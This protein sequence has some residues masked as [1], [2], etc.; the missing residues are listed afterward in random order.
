MFVLERATKK[1]HGDLKLWWF[2]LDIAKKQKAFSRVTE[3]LTKL[4]RLH[5]TKAEVW[6][7]A[8]RYAIDEHGDM[9]EAR[10][11]FQRGLRFCTNSKELWLSYARAELNYM[12][13]IITRQQILGLID[14]KTEQKNGGDLDDPNADIV[15]LPAIT[16]QDV[17][18]SLRATDD[19]DGDALQALLKTPALSGAIPIAIFDAATAHFGD[20]DFSGKYFDLI[21]DLQ[22]IPCSPKLSQHVLDHMKTNYPNDPVTL[23]CF[24]RQPLVGISPQT[25]EFP[26][27]LSV[28]FT[29]LTSSL[30]DHLS[31]GL[32]HKTALWVS[33]YLKQELNE[34]VRAALQ[35]LLLRTLTSYK[36]FA[37]ATDDASGDDSASIF[38]LIARNATD[39]VASMLPWALDLWPSNERLIHLRDNLRFEGEVVTQ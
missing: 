8:A 38:E 26:Q 33:Q 6:R 25:V 7:Y 21:C 32:A 30:D 16:A 10:S 36:S 5:P 31:I 27:A 22:S 9:T 13:K 3:V 37:K 34:S 24:I 2:Y 23:D 20:V 11:H 18:P 12:L 17:D 29:R 15:A 39:V 1:F 14:L 28:T 4:L 19:A 35:A